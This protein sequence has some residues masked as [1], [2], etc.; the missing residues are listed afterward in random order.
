MPQTP[1]PLKRTPVAI[2]KIGPVKEVTNVPVARLD[3]EPGQLTG[4][5]RHPVPVIGYVLEGEFVVK[6]QGQAEQRYSAGD[7]IYEPAN[8]TIERFDNASDSQPASVIAHYL[9]SDGEPELI[10]LL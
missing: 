6:I 1:A 7:S 2:H 10:K 4:M 8:M 5:H 3:F 9:A